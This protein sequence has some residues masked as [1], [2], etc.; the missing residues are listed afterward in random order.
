[1]RRI[2]ANVLIIS[3][4]IVIMLLLL[5]VVV[6]VGGK[7]DADGQF[8][9]SGFSLEP[10]ALPVNQLRIDVEGYIANK[11][12]SAVVY[13][14][15][16]GWTY[17]PNSIRQAG[18]FTIN[19]SGFRSKHN[20]TQV[21]PSDTLRIALFGDS[22][23]AGDDVGDDEV[24]GRQLEILL[25]EA[26]FRAEVLN[27]GVGAYGMDQAF[28][29]WKE[30]GKYYVPDIV[31]LG[32]QPENL[33]RNLNVFRQ[34]MHGSGPPFSKPRF[35]VN[36]DGLEL[37]NSPTLP[38]EELIAAFA[39]F[40]NHPLAPHEY[41]Y[42]SRYV[43]SNWWAP[44]RLASLLYAVV[45]Q[46]DEDE[47]IYEQNTEGGQLGRAIIDAFAEDVEG[48]DAL[49]VVAHLP[50]QWHLGHYYHAS[51]PR[52][53]P[54]QFLLDHCRDNFLYIAT[55]EHIASSYTEDQYW[56]TTKHYG[57]AIHSVVA[58]VVAQELIDCLISGACHV[59]R[60]E[61]PAAFLISD[62]SRSS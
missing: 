4:S 40:G 53:P 16:L 3:A 7:T 8:A 31:I 62:S 46:K 27:F 18:T 13:D 60:F 35:V 34:L 5:E 49:F 36:D 24:W 30:Q 22:F 21:P 44:S 23:T 56:T 12:I 6:R 42:A 58:E 55:E 54:F 32:L 39:D 15:K 28:L 25:G 26:G 50:L 29:R 57:P 61:N 47:N 1:M 45:N 37:L 17:R 10:F 59:P 41:Y 51:P 33:A 9:F 48:Q 43:S 11:D 52:Q 2:V 20:Y 14:E 19:D 38:P